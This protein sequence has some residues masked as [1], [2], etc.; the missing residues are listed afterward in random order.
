LGSPSGV[1]PPFCE[2]LSSPEIRGPPTMLTLLL[3]GAFFSTGE[4][5]NSWCGTLGPS[6]KGP[7][8]GETPL[9]GMKNIWH[10][11]LKGRNLRIVFPRKC[12]QM[13][14]PSKSS[15]PQFG[16]ALPTCDLPHFRSNPLVR[17]LS[18]K[19]NFLGKFAPSKKSKEFQKVSSSK[20]LAFVLAPIPINAPLKN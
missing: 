2:V 12:L 3:K 16:N 7:Q 13:C 4:S 1:V 6:L 20:K 5:Q 11:A 19:K 15:S 17:P 14:A 8:R 9:W 10:P 18:S